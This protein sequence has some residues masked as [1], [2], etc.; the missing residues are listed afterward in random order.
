MRKPQQMKL[1]GTFFELGSAE[2]MEAIGIAGYD[3]VIIDGEHGPFGPVEAMGLIRAA[4]LKGT[5]AFVRVAEI[6]RSAVLKMLDVGAKGLIVPCV[7]TLDQVKDLIRWA[8]YAPVGQRGFFM[9]RPGDYG[10]H[11]KAGT[12]AGYMDYMNSQV[13]LIPQCETQGAL[14]SIE[15]IVALEGVDGIFV[16]PFDLSIAMGMP[17]AFDHP[18]FQQALER[19]LNATHREGKPA[20]IFAPN[21]EKAKEYYAMGFDAVALS[22]DV[23]F[24]IDALKGAKARVL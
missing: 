18:D 16:G 19:I 8:K 21:E 2:A 12:V 17:G 5:Q 23:G 3:F 9:A 24:L 6:S 11:E 10:H 4:E 13:Q 14:E 22:M 7:E 20:Y 15:A 1:L